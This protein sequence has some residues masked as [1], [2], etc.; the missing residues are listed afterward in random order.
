MSEPTTLERRRIEAEILAPVLDELTAEIGAARAEAVL[1]R[2]VAR[3]ARAR[4]E[5]LRREHLAG[6]LE[7]V[8]ALWS[9][10]AQGGALTVAIER[11]EEG[12][13]LRIDRCAYAEH[14]RAQGAERLGRILSCGRDAAVVEGYSRDI[15]MERTRC[16]MDG[17]SCCR[18]L[19]R[20]R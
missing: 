3:V 8:A 17:D 2:A 18:F 7:G 9:Q 5:A 1:A 13:G 16:L 11:G 20:K 14:Y 15:A 4:G 6:D 12:L 19:Y 10:L